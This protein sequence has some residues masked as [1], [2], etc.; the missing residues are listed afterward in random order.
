[1]RRALA[2]LLLLPLLA[3]P[4]AAAPQDPRIFFASGA[5]LALPGG[6]H[7]RVLSMLNITRHMSYGD[8][9]WNEDGVPAG[10]AKAPIWV[11][12][13]LSRQLLSVFRGGHEIG[14]AV[15]LF[16]SDGKPTPL[17]RFSILEKDAHHVSNLYD[18][19]MPFMLRLTND[20]VAIHAANVRQGW[21]THGCVGLPPDF[22]EKLFA[23]AR[24][25]DMVVIVSGDAKKA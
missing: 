1:M 12:I 5:E 25:G 3:S 22:A 14:A 10:S 20:G 21:A 4:V 17:G 7:Q 24:R 19:P 9:V 6:A 2:I 23:T 8:F 16:G 15:I 11:R 18:A 13:D